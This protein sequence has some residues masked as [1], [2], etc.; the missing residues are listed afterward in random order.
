M[1]KGWLEQRMSLR[2]KLKR[3]H[4]Q[5]CLNRRA[6]TISLSSQTYPWLGQPSTFPSSSLEQAKS[7]H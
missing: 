2:N 3:V 6:K 4:G 7:F 5:S 1:W